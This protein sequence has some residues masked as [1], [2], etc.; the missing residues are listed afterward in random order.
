MA[1]CCRSFCALFALFT[2]FELVAAATSEA[3][4]V[5]AVS[6][7]PPSAPWTMREGLADRLQKT[8]PT[9]NPQVLERTLTAIRCAIAGVGVADSGRAR[10]AEPHVLAL[11]DYSLPSSE[12]RLWLFDLDTER[13]LFHELVA[14]GM[15]SGE[16]EAVHFSNEVGTQ[17]SSLGLFRA[18]ETYQG[19]NGYSLRL[20]GLEAGFNDRARERAIVIHGA[21]YVDGE[22]LAE[23]GR[24]G[25]SWGCP[26][27]DIRVARQAMTEAV[28]LGRKTRRGDPPCVESCRSV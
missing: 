26:A 28:T 27:L 22:F 5:E 12:K 3:F 25:R 4:A 10:D 17:A 20:D 6:A 7:R 8:S 19:R 9:L 13:L 11:V 2:L 1:G 16:N 18:A 21:W 23:H 24:L 15:G 14:H